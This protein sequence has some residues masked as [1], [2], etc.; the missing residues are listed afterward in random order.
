MSRQLQ[1]LPKV[2]QILKESAEGRQILNSYK[3]TKCL[4]RLGRRSIVEILTTFLLNHVEG[5]A[6]HKDFQYFSKELIKK[7]TNEDVNYYYIAPVPKSKSF[8]SK[9]I[10]VR[11][12]LALKYWN[13]LKKFRQLDKSADT[14]NST[15]SVSVIEEAVQLSIDWLRNNRAPWDLILRHWEVTSDV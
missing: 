12:R 9:S 15:Q 2:D 8:T 11:G 6:N 5:N 3:K 1:Q 7:F 14:E 4:T 13:K 10:S